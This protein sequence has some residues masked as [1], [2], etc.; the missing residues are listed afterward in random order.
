MIEAVALQMEEIAMSTTPPRLQDLK[1]VKAQLE[2]WSVY[3]APKMIHL[4]ID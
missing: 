3:Q 1:T 4:T 2:I